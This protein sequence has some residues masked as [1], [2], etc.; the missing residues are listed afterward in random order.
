MPFNKIGKLCSLPDTLAI[1]DSSSSGKDALCT[2]VVFHHTGTPRPKSI[3]MK[4]KAA[5]IG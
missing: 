4:V 3:T 1:L 2:V 5:P